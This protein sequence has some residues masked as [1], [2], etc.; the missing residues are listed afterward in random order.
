MK[1][2]IEC[3]QKTDRFCEKLKRVE[4]SDFRTLNSAWE[5]HKIRNEIAHQGSGYKLTRREAEMAIQLFKQV[6]EEF[7]FI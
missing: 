6:F 5:A 2:T 4:P 1:N 3:F 7:Y